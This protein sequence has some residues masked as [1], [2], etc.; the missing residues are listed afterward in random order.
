MNHQ[1]HNRSWKVWNLINTTLHKS[2]LYACV[3]SR[4]TKGIHIMNAIKINYNCFNEP[5]AV[6]PCK[7][8]YWDMHGLIF[9]TSIWLLAGSTRL[10]ELHT[11]RAAKHRHGKQRCKTSNMTVSYENMILQIRSMFDAEPTS[12]ELISSR[13][14]FV[15][16]PCHQWNTQASNATH[17]SMALEKR[18]PNTTHPRSSRIA[19]ARKRW[20]FSQAKLDA[21]TPIREIA[22]KKKNSPHP[23]PPK[24]PKKTNPHRSRV[25]AYTHNSMTAFEI[26]VALRHLSQKTGPI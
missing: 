10:M 18:T 24:K 23:V 2:G 8:W 21:K 19:P 15:E 14:R 6:L 26:S 13:K 12:A 3:S 20:Q 7:S 11:N 16:P 25:P 9:D 1:E 4:I 5:F 22:K 17:A